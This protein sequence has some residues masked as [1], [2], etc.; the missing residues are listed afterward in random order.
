M[1]NTI[2]LLKDASLI[3]ILLVFGKIGSASATTFE[4]YVRGNVSSPIMVELNGKTLNPGQ[5]T[6]NLDFDNANVIL[7]YDDKS[8]SSVSDDIM[9]ITGIVNGLTTYANYDPNVQKL[10]NYHFAVGHYTYEL[11][12]NA[13]NPIASMTTG[14]NDFAFGQQAAGT[15]KV[16]NANPNWDALPYW[17]SVST[18]ML[19][20]DKNF[21]F[22]VYADP[23]NSNKLI[24]EGW[25]ALMAGFLGVGNGSRWEFGTKNTNLNW[26]F[27]LEPINGSEVPEPFTAGLLSLGLFGTVLKRRRSNL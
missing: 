18:V 14:G 13:S 16:T 19:K 15:V 10:S 5:A 4:Y 25:V 2:N 1:K 3:T 24:G 26:D 11:N 23:N 6:F 12:I 20:N 8:T 27:S 7:K 9:T 21:A 22:D 17:D